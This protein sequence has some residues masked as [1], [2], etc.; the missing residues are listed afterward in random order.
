MAQPLEISPKKNDIPFDT[1]HSSF[2]G[3]L[4]DLEEL[5]KEECVYSND[6]LNSQFDGILS[7]HSQLASLIPWTLTND[8]NHA[9]E[10]QTIKLITDPNCITRVQLDLSNQNVINL[11]SKRTKLESEEQ[12]ALME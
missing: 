2:F 9:T 11:D 7:A 6:Q 10:K 12:K 5:T 4:R 1:L 3:L 8:S